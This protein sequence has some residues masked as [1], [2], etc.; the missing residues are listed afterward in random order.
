MHV[1]SKLRPTEF[2]GIYSEVSANRITAL[3]H[4]LWPLYS[5][6]PLGAVVL[7]LRKVVPS[8]SDIRSAFW[9]CLGS[10]VWGD[11]MQLLHASEGL[12]EASKW[13]FWFSMKL[14]VSIK[15]LLE[16]F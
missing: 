11:S 4:K 14:E 10:E 1:Y 12:P 6:V 5:E 8:S 9:F 2:N 7:T 13:P 3:L 16:Y 15:S